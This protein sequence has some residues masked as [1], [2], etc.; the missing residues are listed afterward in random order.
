MR[1]LRQ[2]AVLAPLT[3][4]RARAYGQASARLRQHPLP[5]PPIAF[6]DYNGYTCEVREVY[7]ASCDLFIG[8]AF[9]DGVDK[10]EMS[11]QTRGG[12]TESYPS[13]CVLCQKNAM[14]V[15]GRNKSERTNGSSNASFAV[16]RSEEIIL[17][18]CRLVFI[19][20]RNDAIAVNRAIPNSNCHAATR[21]VKR[22]NIAHAF[23]FT[24]FIVIYIY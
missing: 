1:T 15:R 11:T 10:G 18:L 3:S 2:R 13:R 6:H 12:A 23:S 19:F 22:K 14:E 5:Y 20:L 21:R 9:E 7:C 4:G 17:A 24:T 16:W 8:H